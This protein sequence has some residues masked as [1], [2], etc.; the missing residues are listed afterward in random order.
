M[1]NV[2]LRR[3]AIVSTQHACLL[4]LAFPNAGTISATTDLGIVWAN[5]A[6]HTEL[7]SPIKGFDFDKGFG[8]LSLYPVSLASQTLLPS[9]SIQ[10]FMVNSSGADLYQCSSSNPDL[11][12]GVSSYD[13]LSFGVSAGATPGSGIRGQITITGT[14]SIV[15][16]SPLL[17]FGSIGPT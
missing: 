15:I 17:F 16:P 5:P 8:Y 12:A 2:R 7:L 11:N 10:L 9:V 3:P 14:Y 4:S 1:E 13:V 6:D